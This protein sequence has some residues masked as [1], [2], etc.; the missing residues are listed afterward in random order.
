[1]DNIDISKQNGIA[2][3]VL[4]AKAKNE[5]EEKSFDQIQK[6]DLMN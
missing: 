4:E 5:T 3:S 1:M 2:K 6:E